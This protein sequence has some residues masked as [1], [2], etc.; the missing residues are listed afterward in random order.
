MQRS[1][2]SGTGEAVASQLGEGQGLGAPN[3]SHP[4]PLHSLIG[5]ASFNW[6][7]KPWRWLLCLGADKAKETPSPEETMPSEAALP[8][9][10]L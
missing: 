6:V 9:Q 2:V 10:G 5:V 7:R 1:D 4:S 8:V 3:L